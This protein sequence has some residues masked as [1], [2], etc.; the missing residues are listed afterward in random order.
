MAWIIGDSF[1]FYA[2]R[3][4]A[5]GHWDS[6]IA[7]TISST[8][9]FSTGRS[10]L[11][12]NI[13]TG[14]TKN[15]SS[16]EATLFC[17]FA[18]YCEA[19]SSGSTQ[20]ANIQFLDGGTV[21]CT[22]SFE[23]PG[24]IVLRSGG[25]AG[26]VLAT[27]SS[28]WSQ[29]VWDHF[30]I[31]VV[32]D[33]SSTPVGSITVR[34]NGDTSD[35][36]SATGLNTRGGTANNYANAVRLTGSN[37]VVNACFDDFLCFSGS[38][39]APNTWVGDIRAVQLMPS[40]DTAQKQFAAVGSNA[41]TIWSGGTNLVGR[42]TNTIYYVLFVAA[43]TGTVAKIGVKFNSGVTGH[44][45]VALYD[46]T[47]A[48]GIPGALLA[49]SAEVANP[50]TG[51]NDFTFSSPPSVTA[52]TTYYAAIL[53][54]VAW[55]NAGQV[56]TTTIYTESQTYGSGFP[57]TATPSPVGTY[58]GQHTITIT[59]TNSY[60]VNEAIEDADASYV[61][62]STSGHEDLYDLAN[63]AVTPTSIV[64]VQSRMFAKKSDSGSRNG[65]IRVKSGG[66]E[67]G[68]T[69]TVLST[70]YGWLN[71]VDAV[72]PNTSAAWTASAVNALQVGPKVT[73]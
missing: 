13:S 61:Y 60:C 28:A 66:T 32:I 14:L 3:A 18:H 9:R 11:F 71:R 52:G 50:I 16:N 34:K 49:T 62:D 17:A 40:A 36:W 35:T 20:V 5:A 27:Y 2:A 26:S 4:D 44:A 1:D 30:Q 42:S 39:P 69:D 10:F 63:L 29:G 64:G 6:V 46:A 25:I 43:A 56:A 19:G 59:T 68:G 67:V 48:G 33:G 51:N 8:T 58:A 55:N 65:Q 38:D 22:I 54:D 24:N 70:T 57:S 45:K 15:L 31:K 53:T 72:D 7:G 12:G 47:G 21:Q 23:R 41:T 73:A 37:A